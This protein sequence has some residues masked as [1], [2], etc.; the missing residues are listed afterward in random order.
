MDTRVKVQNR[1]CR[2]NQ[3]KASVQNIFEPQWLRILSCSLFLP[4]LGSYPCHLVRTNCLSPSPSSFGHSTK[5]STCSKK[6]ISRTRQI[7]VSHHQEDQKNP[8]LHLSQTSSFPC[9]FLLT[10]FTFFTFFHL[11]CHDHTMLLPSLHHPPK[12]P[13]STASFLRFPLYLLPFPLSFS[14]STSLPS[15]LHPV[16]VRLRTF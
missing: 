2:V 7:K 11:P 14:F 5:S 8:F 1:T 12:T 13:I 3:G 16:I 10:F 9:F 6:N 4:V 15:F